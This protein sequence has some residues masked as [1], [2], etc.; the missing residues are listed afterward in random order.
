[1]GVLRPPRAA[2]IASLIYVVLARLIQNC[3]RGI[4]IVPTH[5]TRANAERVKR[6]RILYPTRLY[7]NKKWASLLYTAIV[8]GVFRDVACEI[9]CF[10]LKITPQWVPVAGR[11][12]F[13]RVLKT[14][15]RTLMRRFY[16]STFIRK[17][18]LVI[19]RVTAYGF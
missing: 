2:K 19:I 13:P 5:T 7:V 18:T 10:S 9:Y 14:I 4:V 16:C 15:I 17:T 3:G 8:F 6:T 11:T 1:M 12:G